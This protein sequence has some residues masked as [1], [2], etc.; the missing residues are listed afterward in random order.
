LRPLVFLAFCPFY[1]KA[2][3]CMCGTIRRRDTHPVPSSL[4]PPPQTWAG[5][6]LEMASKCG[7]S[8]DLAAAFSCI[9]EFVSGVQR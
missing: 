9:A 6:F 8:Q 3:D 4:G 7:L 2:E 1:E 5:P